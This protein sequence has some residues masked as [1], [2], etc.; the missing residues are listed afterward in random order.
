MTG[1]WADSIEPERIDE[2]GARGMHATKFNSVGFS[3]I[4]V[5]ASRCFIL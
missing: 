5:A 3:F 4:Y 2:Y 1:R